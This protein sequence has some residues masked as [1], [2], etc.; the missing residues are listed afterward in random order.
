MALIQVDCGS[1]PVFLKLSA[2]EPLHRRG[3][4]HFRKIPHT[5]KYLQLNMKNITPVVKVT[6]A[7]LAQIRMGVFF[8]RS[9]SDAIFAMLSFFRNHGGPQFEKHCSIIL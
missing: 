4:P 1:V 3:P 2:I 5:P 8:I 7:A 9:V 6:K